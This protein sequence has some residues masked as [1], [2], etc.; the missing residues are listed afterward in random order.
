VTGAGARA[1]TDLVLVRHGH[2]QSDVDRIV[3]GCRGC[4]GLSDLGRWQA[5][6]LAPRLRAL[7][8]GP[9]DAAYASDLPRA[10]ETAA[11]ALAWAGM[12]VTERADLRE[13]EPGAA[14]GLDRAEAARIARIGDPDVPTFD[15][16]ESVNAFD[17]RVRRA[18]DGVV[19]AHAGQTVV[20]VTHGGFI[21]AACF[22][23]MGQPTSSAPKPFRLDAAHASITQWTRAAD[24]SGPWRLERYND[25]ARSPRA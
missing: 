18:L 4:R 1:R 22:A 9:P 15:G 23:L 6:A 12:A 10:R 7:L 3:P 25:G 20:L 14:D 11:L 8:G 16:G 17:R 24:G 21:A 5:T 2:P 13:I 19:S